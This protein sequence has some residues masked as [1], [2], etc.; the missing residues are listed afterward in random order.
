[1]R[2]LLADDHPTILAGMQALLRGVPR[3]QV[4]GTAGDGD[5]LIALLERAAC[6]AVI[7]DYAM[8]GSRRGDGL[9]LLGF[10]RR[11]YPRVI[12][13]LHT[14]QESPA[15]LAKARRLG[16]AQMV[17]K[18]DASGHLAAALQ[19]AMVGGDYLS[20]AI[21]AHLAAASG[22]P[23]QLTAREQEVVRLFVSGM[24]INAIASQL[25][26]SKQTISSQKSSAMRKLEVAHDAD[27][28]RKWLQHADAGAG[29]APP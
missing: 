25:H 13:I 15:I 2:L 10:L 17:S 19:A 6:D 16:I 14:M 21:A 5:A 11:R 27:L 9:T 12:L 4:V 24:S 20:P 23:A 22:V 28:V 3:V 1:M 7:T 18:A 8:P 29:P 26:R